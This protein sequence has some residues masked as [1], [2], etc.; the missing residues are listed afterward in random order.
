MVNQMKP[1]NPIDYW[2]LIAMAAAVFVAGICTG[3]ATKPEQVGQQCGAWNSAVTLYEAAIAAGHKPS[4]DEALAYAAAKTMMGIYCAGA[5]GATKGIGKIQRPP[6]PK[7]LTVSGEKYKLVVKFEILDTQGESVFRGRKDISKGPLYR[8]I[9][10]RGEPPNERDGW[11][12][13]PD[14]PYL[15]GVNRR[16]TT[17]HPI[18]QSSNAGY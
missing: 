12:Y 3:C 14:A 18:M 2:T 7:T 10:P 16:P 6:E 11:L 4:E 1:L 5:G 13:I 17:M 15:I 9:K 8:R